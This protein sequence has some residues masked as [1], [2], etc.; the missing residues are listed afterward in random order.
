MH[1]LSRTLGP[2]LRIVGLLLVAAVLAAQASDADVARGGELFAG[3][4]A[5]ANRGP[6]CISCHDAVKAARPDGGS[7]AP[8][9]AR[10]HGRLGGTRGLHDWLAAPPTPVMRTTFH[11]VPLQPA[12]VRALTAYLER[13]AA[14]KS[15]PV[16]RP[17]G[18]H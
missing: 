4:S 7:P 9:L 16:F 13:L 3:T 18:A 2:I 1:R 8:N 10:A 6:A 14:G 11:S 5:L 15:G 17:R 12:E